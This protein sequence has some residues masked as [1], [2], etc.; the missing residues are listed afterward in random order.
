[1]DG[2]PARG[3]ETAMKFV[4]AVH[5]TRGDVEPCAAVG[6]EL[7]R[8]G[9]NVRMA[10]PPNMIGFVESA[11]LDG[12]PYGPDSLA[13]LEEPIFRKWWNIRN[14]I[15]VVREATEYVTRGWAEM[16]AALTLLADGADLILSGQTYQGVPANIAEYYDIPFA[17]VHCFPYRRNGQLISFL[18]PPVVRLGMA[19]AE[20]VYWRATKKAE[21]AQRRALGLPKTRLSSVRRIAQRGWLEIQAY[22]ELYFP[23]LAAEWN[24]RRPF[25]GALTLEMPT[26]SDDEI[27]SWIAAGPPPVY[28]GFGSMRVESP[29]ATIGMIADACAQLGERA[30]ISSGGVSDFD[31]IPHYDHV[32]VVG[33]VNHAAIFPACRAFV[34][35][36]GPGTLLAGM[37]AGIPTLVLW[38][39]AEQPIWAA[40]VK[41]LKIGSAR[42]F[43]NATPESLVAD[44]RT[45]LAPEYV[46]RASE[47]ATQM[48]KTEASVTRA[49]DLLEDAAQNRNSYL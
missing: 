29:A 21:D 11:G 12:V 4:V 15:S 46:A 27:L 33:A 37:R 18:P 36:G 35:H 42:R 22:D 19:V 26:N 2:P 8:R 24:D 41:R 40:V 9:H 20:W 28:F 3:E 32:K 31:D 13:Q 17:A 44:L 16:S 39:G 14:P 5:G 43:S 23:G 1:M 47:I 7:L 49:A 38:I 34:H 25:V 45:I 48:T 6:L 30:L 10:V